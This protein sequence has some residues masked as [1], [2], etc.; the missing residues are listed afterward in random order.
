MFR[1]KKWLVQLATQIVPQ[2][3]FPETVILLQ[4]S[5]VEMV[6]VCSPFYHKIFERKGFKKIF[7][8]TVT[9]FYWF[10]KDILKWAASFL[11]NWNTVTALSTAVQ[12]SANVNWIK[13][14]ISSNLRK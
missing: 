9:I 6:Y 12:Y 7:L 3:L 4:A 13:I 1:E 2:I 11:F 5:S 8:I 14:S 10:I